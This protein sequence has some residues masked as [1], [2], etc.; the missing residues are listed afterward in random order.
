MTRTI[1]TIFVSSGAIAVRAADIA[2]ADRM[3]DAYC[4][5]AAAALGAWSPE[6]AAFREDVNAR[7][8]AAPRDE[9]S[10]IREHGIEHYERCEAMGRFDQDRDPG[11]ENDYVGATVTVTPFDNAGDALDA[12]HAAEWREFMLDIGGPVDSEP[13]A[14]DRRFDAMLDALD[15]QENDALDAL[16]AAIDDDTFVYVPEPEHFVTITI[17]VDA[18][19]GERGREIEAADPFTRVLQRADE[20]A[21][22]NERARKLV[23]IMTTVGIMTTVH[24]EARKLAD[25]MTT[26]DIM[27]TGRP[28]GIVTDKHLDMSDPLNREAREFWDSADQERRD[29]RFA[30]A[31]Q[32]RHPIVRERARDE[33]E[34]VKTFGI[35]D[36]AA[37]RANR[38]IEQLHRGRASRDMPRSLSHWGIH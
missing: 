16:E 33:A 26:A 30:E 24:P 12:L 9:S 21:A 38:G 28:R 19:C 29:K 8:I 6:T 18:L 14:R 10:F 20:E 17:V 25:V 11:D 13:P 23:D 37:T 4:N 31:F 32:A 34:A 5:T 7:A 36:A 27:T 22:K 35:G 15:D 2:T 3:V 1:C